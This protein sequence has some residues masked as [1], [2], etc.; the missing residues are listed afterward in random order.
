LLILSL[1]AEHDENND[2]RQYVKRVQW[3][4]TTADNIAH[5]KHIFDEFYA[6]LKLPLD[7]L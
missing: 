5:Y 2:S 3:D 1:A 4:K 6:Q 7:T